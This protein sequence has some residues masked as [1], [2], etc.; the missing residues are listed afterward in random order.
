MT[1]DI[2]SNF[3]YCSCPAQPDCRRCDRQSC[4]CPTG[5]TGCGEGWRT[6]HRV[7]GTVSERLSAGRSGFE[8][9][10]FA[11]L[12][13]SAGRCWSRTAR[14]ADRASSSAC[15]ARVR[16]GGTTLLLSWMV[17]GFWPC[18]TRFDLPNYGEFDEKRVFVEGEMPG[19]VNFRGVRIGC[20]LRRNL[21]R[22]RCVRNIG[23][24][25]VQK[26]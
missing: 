21:E 17:A 22:P 9:G 13:G 4:P 2:A 19:P 16:R 3:R 20:R 8:N 6:P 26:F 10:L 15:H 11:R 23:W 14:M 25:A 18:A 24:R 1:Q 7:H 12:L 5:K